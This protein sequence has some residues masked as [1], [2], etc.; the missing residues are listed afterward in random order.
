MYFTIP[1]TTLNFVA[2]NSVFPYPTIHTLCVYKRMC[3]ITP[4]PNN[5]AYNEGND[6]LRV[7]YQLQSVFMHAISAGHQRNI[8]KLGLADG[9]ELKTNNTTAVLCHTELTGNQKSFVYTV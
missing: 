2:S 9:S 6:D 1:R 5:Q 7:K 8:I 3:P 4:M